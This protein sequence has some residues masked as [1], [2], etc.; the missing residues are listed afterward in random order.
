MLQTLTR[1]FQKHR[2]LTAWALGSLAVQALPPFYHWYLLFVSFSGL[3]E[4]LFSTDNHKQAFKL[5]WWYGF[6]FFSFGLFWI[7]NALM[8]NPEQT[9]WLIPIVFLASGAF[10]GLFIGLPTLLTSLVRSR[11][12]RYLSLCSWIVVFE[13][14]RSWILTGFPW[15]LWGSCLAFS[16]ELLQSAAIF[17]TYG[18]SFALIAVTAAPALLL[19]DHRRAT[20]WSTVAIL[21]L[22]PSLMWGFGHWRL[23]QLNS[24]QGD[25]TIRL[26]Q[27][28]I[29]QGQKWSP[30]LRQQHFE[31]YINLTRSQP[32]DNI[33]MVVWS[34]TA[35]P[36]S[37]D[38][39]PEAMRQLQPVINPRGYLTT[40]VIRYQTDY[41]GGYKPL[42]SSLVIN[43]DGIIEASY[44]KS[45]LVPFGEYIPLREYLPSFI[46]PI[47]NTIGTFLSGNGPQTLK[48]PNLPPF[49]I[50]ICYE[51]IFPHQ[52]IDSASKP[53]WLLNLTNDGWD[54]ISAGPYQH[55]VSTRLRAVEEG[56]TIVRSAGSGI[57]A[58]IDRT[59][60]VIS[61]LELNQSAILDVTLPRDLQISTVFNR[62]GGLLTLT[63]CFINIL[64]AMLFNCRKRIII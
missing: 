16:D 62:F 48:V 9:A 39:D 43:A 29:P 7:N 11:F 46:R 31:Q 57:S 53:E 23:T 44:D 64:I 37:L 24:P 54:G 22:V 51:I 12:G 63:L 60:R 59:G 32:L 19:T 50:Q 25:I 1:F 2:N 36:Y 26:V 10:F 41:Y 28:S 58:V 45:H 40:G 8:I 6:G 15:N 21:I 13:W 34:E 3:L 18:L 56:L 61:S 42:N 47:A 27:P 5:G 38:S 33:D 52:I 49:G 14:I 17:G 30:E 55:L 35:S 20:A 4:L